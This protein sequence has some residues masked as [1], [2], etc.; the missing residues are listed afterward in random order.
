MRHRP[1][2]PPARALPA[3]VGHP[4]QHQRRLYCNFHNKRRGVGVALDGFFATPLRKLCFGYKKSDSLG[5]ALDGFFATPLRDVVD[6]YAVPRH[7]R[8]ATLDGFGGPPYAV[9]FKQRF[10]PTSACFRWTGQSCPPTQTTFSMRTAMGTLDGE[11]PPP[12][13]L[14]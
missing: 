11:F 8:C 3:E 10:W 7:L 9:G 4:A 6:A 1:R 14:Q 5:P 13:T 12:P 2:L